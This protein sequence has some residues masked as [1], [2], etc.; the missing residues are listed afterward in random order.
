[1]AK[2]TVGINKDKE[3]GTYY[4]QKQY[5]GITIKKRGFSTINDAKAFLNNEIY[6]IDHPVEK[7]TR[8]DILLDELFKIYI[9]FRSINIRITTLK[10]NKDKYRIHIQPD[11]GQFLLSSIEPNEIRDWK[12]KFV[13]IGFG[14]DYTNQTIMVFR[15]ILKFGIDRDYH[16][17]KKLISELDK[18]KIQ[19]IP[20]ER[21]ILTY[22]EIDKFLKTF[23][24]DDPTE[25]LYH[26]YFYAFSRSGMRPNEFRGLQVKDLKKDR[27]N[28]N[29]DITSKIIGEGDI[30]QPCK[31]DYS[32]REVIMPKEIMDMLYA[33]TKDYEAND[34][35]FGKSK[36]LR[37]T[38]I[39]RQ[40]DSHLKLAGLK[41]ITIYGFRHSHATHLI[42]NGA[43][44]KV[45]SKRLGH[46]DIQTT[47]NTYQHLLDED[48]ESVIK[49]L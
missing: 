42:R 48:Q 18:V 5:K 28:V 30:I 46:K 26:D 36:A 32:V 35:I 41:H 24:L 9:E 43:M 7:E 16:I 17:N 20:K 15:N 38:N 33:R 31:N 40:L 22:D 23:E 1:M 45:V 25:K 47:L 39:R 11:F 19:T 27:I 12:I 13:K 44:I 29:H 8:K 34:F 37:E 3:R 4:V 49:L 2:N 21:E 14:E 10:G 6:L